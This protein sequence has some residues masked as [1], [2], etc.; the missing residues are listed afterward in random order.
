MD[1]GYDGLMW[2][3][4]AVGEIE[5]G[6]LCFQVKAT[7]NLP[8]LTD[9]A[10]ISWPVNRRDLRLWL[11][12]SYP[13]ILVVYDRKRERAYWLYTQAYFT[14]RSTKDLFS[15]G[16][17]LNVHI[18]TRNRINPKSIREIAKY[19]QEIDRQLSGKVHHHV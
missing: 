7:E 1:Y 15:A 6:F 11:K 3:Y 12:E 5:S 17:T 14:T 2:T 10:T 19:K 9:E 16:E 8:L 13:V 18:P 4:N